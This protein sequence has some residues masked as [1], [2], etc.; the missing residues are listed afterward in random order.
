LTLSVYL[1]VSPPV[2]DDTLVGNTDVAEVDTLR[3]TPSALTARTRSFVC[4][5]SPKIFPKRSSGS[6]LTIPAPRL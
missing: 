3:P 5:N 4:T 1:S 6:Q 2:V